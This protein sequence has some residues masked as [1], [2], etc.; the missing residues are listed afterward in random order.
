MSNQATP[1]RKQM[2]LYHVMH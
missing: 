1:M 2:Q